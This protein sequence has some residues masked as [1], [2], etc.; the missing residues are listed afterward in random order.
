MLWNAAALLLRSC[1]EAFI[2]GDGVVNGLAQVAQE[3]GAGDDTFLTE[4]LRNQA[5]Q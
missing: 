2:L 4:Q 3:L 5:A 1:T